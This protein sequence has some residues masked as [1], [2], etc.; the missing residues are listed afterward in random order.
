MDHT[1]LLPRDQRAVPVWK[2]DEQ[3]RRPEIEVGAFGLRAVRSRRRIAAGDGIRVPCCYLARP[4][5]LSGIEVEGHEGIGS[6]GWRVRITVSRGHINRALRGVDGGRTPYRSTGRPVKLDPLLVLTGG[7]RFLRDGKRLPDGFAGGGV[8]CRDAPPEA[9]A[10]VIGTG[11]GDLFTR[12][13]RH[14][15]APFKKRGASRDDRGRVVADAGLP[16]DFARDS[17][18][19][20]SIGVLV[21]EEGCPAPALPTDG[22]GRAHGKI[23]L[24]RPVSAA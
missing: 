1:R 12:R 8:K 6:A 13:N 9:A 21:A 2:V 5:Q 24:R 19:G 4:E 18:G 17:V 3:G 11:S 16:E 20:I 10:G 23:H 22:D 15:Q 7:L 14:V